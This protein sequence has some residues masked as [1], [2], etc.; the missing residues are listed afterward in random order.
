VW[1]KSDLF[2]WDTCNDALDVRQ[3][4]GHGNQCINVVE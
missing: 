3:R 1:K 4:A 2:F